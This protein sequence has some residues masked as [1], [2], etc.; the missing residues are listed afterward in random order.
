VATKNVAHFLLA[1]LTGGV[2]VF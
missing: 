1:T 2:G